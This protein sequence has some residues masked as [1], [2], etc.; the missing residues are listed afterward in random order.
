MFLIAFASAATVFVVA[1]AN[2]EESTKPQRCTKRN[3]VSQ[4]EP[5]IAICSYFLRRT[6]AASARGPTAQAIARRNLRSRIHSYCALVFA[7]NFSMRA[8][9][10]SSR[11]R[12]CRSA[13]DFLS[14]AV[15]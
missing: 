3:A 1:H 15:L 10:F 4:L 5:I 13:Y 14:S 2:S 6:R 9:S 11:L 8:R 7:P 12:L